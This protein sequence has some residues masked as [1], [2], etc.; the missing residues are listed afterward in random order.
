MNTQELKCFLRVAERMSFTRAAEELYLTPPTVT[1]HIQKLESEL[2]VR[3]LQRNSK[4]VYLTLEGKTFYQDAQ[5]IMMKIEASF[6]HLNDIR[7][8]KHALLRIGCI[9]AQEAAPLSKPLSYLR[10]QFPDVE[11]RIIISD[12]SQQLRMLKEDHLDILLG[13]RD[14]ITNQEDFR[15]TLL[16][17]CR[18][19]VV[20]SDNY[21]NDLLSDEVSL[22]D[23]E[24]YPLI[25]LHS[26]SFPVQ[27]DDA[28]EKFLTIKA[29]FMHIVRQEDVAAVI[30]LVSSGYGVG[31][32]P[33][34]VLA[35]S[36]KASIHYARIKES[37]RIEY[38]IIRGATAKNPYIIRFSD[39]LSAY[40]L[41]EQI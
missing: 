9:T 27:P 35:E 29:R 2:G 39:I 30:A 28:I 24:N 41:G 33:E 14:M 32:L 18:S 20:F 8:S 15:F 23:L 11:P 40:I 22:T 37:P 34:Y 3:L 21:R 17:N 19:C 25:A 16:Y 10:E 5:E 31:I 38:G 13:T 7:N 4:S 1:H 12:F 36:V 26:K 6:S